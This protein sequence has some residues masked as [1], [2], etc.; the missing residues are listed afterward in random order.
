MAA[1]TNC[2][3]DAPR[4]NLFVLATMSGGAYLGSVKIRNLSATG[5]LVEGSCLPAAGTKFAL[6]RG[7]STASGVIAWS[8]GDKAGLKMDAHVNVAQWMP[9]KHAHQNSIDALVDKVKKE[10]PLEP[11][12]AD[13]GNSAALGANALLALAESISVLADALASD[14]R[15]VTQFGARLQ[16]LDIAS[17]VLQKLA[18]AR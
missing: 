13:P 6:Y 16:T 5:A 14:E 4:K 9:G 11:L 2:L 15:V 7:G 3:R 1:L 10:A 12:A 18:A 17:Q 8:S